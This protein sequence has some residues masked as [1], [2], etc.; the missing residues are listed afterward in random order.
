MESKELIQ[1]LIRVKSKELKNQMYIKSSHLSDEECEWLNQVPPFHITKQLLDCNGK[2]AIC[3]AENPDD[4]DVLVVGDSSHT[5]NPYWYK[6]EEIPFHHDANSIK[7]QYH[8]IDLLNIYNAIKHDKKIIAWGSGAFLVTLIAGCPVIQMAS[9]HEP[10]GSEVCKHNV[11]FIDRSL[12]LVA[13][14][15]KEIMYPF[16]RHSYDFDNEQVVKMFEH[17]QVYTTPYIPNPRDNYKILAWADLNDPLGRVT[18]S[19]MSGCKGE[20]YPPTE[21]LY[22]GLS[23]GDK[24]IFAEHSLV[25]PE[26]VLY[27]NINALAITIDVESMYGSSDFIEGSSLVSSIVKLFLEDKL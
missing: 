6:D 8:Y 23:K 3:S 22:F 21:E 27:N 14:D 12:A 11:S 25:E 24:K 17:D 20:L 13:S 15:H 5:I 4:Y 7:N 19:F 18:R 16:V 26:I 2:D 10:K 1:K 9:D